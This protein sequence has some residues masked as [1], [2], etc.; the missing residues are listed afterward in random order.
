MAI[1]LANRE[2]AGTV[3]RGELAFGGGTAENKEAEGRV[4]APVLCASDAAFGNSGHRGRAV[5]GAWGRL[6]QITS[7]TSTS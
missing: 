4:A 5:S 6:F 3:C 7:D 1:S 2:A